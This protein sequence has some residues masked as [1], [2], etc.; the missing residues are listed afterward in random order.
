MTT[1]AEISNAADNVYAHNA[2]EYL[3]LLLP[4]AEAASQLDSPLVWNTRG[5][6]TC[7]NCGGQTFNEKDEWHEDNCMWLAL[8]NALKALEKGT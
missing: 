1:L 8:Q 3:R 6:Y 2:I 7:A 4:I 5:Y